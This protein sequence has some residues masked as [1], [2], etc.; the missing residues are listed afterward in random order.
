ME[1]RIIPFEKVPEFINLKEESDASW[2]C[3]TCIYGPLASACNNCLD[4]SNYWIK[5]EEEN[6]R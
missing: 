6:D 4:G 5:K 1:Q 3:R 2:S